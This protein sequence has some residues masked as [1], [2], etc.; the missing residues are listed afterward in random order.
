MYLI[1]LITIAA[2]IVEYFILIYSNDY[3][4][5]II[6]TIFTIITYIIF[7]LFSLA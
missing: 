1:C 4:N 7:I 6:Y 2:L 3:F 5:K